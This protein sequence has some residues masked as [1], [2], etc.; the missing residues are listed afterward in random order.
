MTVALNVTFC[1]NAAGF[2]AADAKVK[3]GAMVWPSAFDDGGGPFSPLPENLEV[4]REVGINLRRDPGK[5]SR[6]RFTSAYR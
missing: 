2:G 6:Q 1:P 4:L 3:V 5:E